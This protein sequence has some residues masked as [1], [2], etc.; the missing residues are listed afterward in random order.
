MI[1][2]LPH[3]V[4]N[5]DVDVQTLQI[6][7]YRRRN[8]AHPIRHVAADANDL[9]FADECF[10]A[11]VLFATLHHLPDPARALAHLKR[12]LK[13]SGFPFA[14]MIPC[15][16]RAKPISTAS[17]SLGSLFIA[18]TFSSLPASSACR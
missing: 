12:L 1:R 18:A 6:G 2:G 17:R 10:D 16:R 11:V 7:A 3:E 14:T 8:D 9:P 13:P 15:S 5:I 4:Y